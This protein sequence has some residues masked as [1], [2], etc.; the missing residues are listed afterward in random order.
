MKK[1]ILMSR[2][3]VI[4]LLMSVIVFFTGCGYESPYELYYEDSMIESI[5]IIMVEEYL[6][7]VDDFVEVK[8]ET[9][10]VISDKD[11]FLEDFSKVKFSMY[12]FGDPLSPP[13][14][15]GFDAILVKYNN[16]DEEYIQAEQVVLNKHGELIGGNRRSRDYKAWQALMDK[17]LAK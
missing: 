16:G 13:L 9:L 10:L 4:I 8:Y 11:T 6:Y 5:E 3:S 1:T 7:K 15:S 17:Y 12:T 14:V 2:V